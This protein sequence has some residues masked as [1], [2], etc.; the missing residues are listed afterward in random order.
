[1][2][3]PPPPKS[4]RCCCWSTSRRPRRRR[5]RATRAATRR[6]SWRRLRRRRRVVV[7]ETTRSATRMGRWRR[8]W[9]TTW[10]ARGRW[11]PRPRLPWP[12][13]RR[14]PE[15]CGLRRSGAC[16]ARSAPPCASRPTTADTW[17]GEPCAHYVAWCA[18][19]RWC[20]V[21]RC[22]GRCTSPCAACR[23]SSEPR[24]A[25]AR[26]AS[27]NTRSS[28]SRR[29]HLQPAVP[30][31]CWERGVHYASS[32]HCR[33]TTTSVTTARWPICCSSREAG[34]EAGLEEATITA[35]RGALP[36]P[37]T[38]VAAPWRTPGRRARAG[39][40]PPH[41]GSGR[42]PTPTPTS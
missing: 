40:T 10:S 32:W 5:R 38:A 4:Q 8:S 41:A 28:S 9:P 14:L 20:A 35:A 3:P 12:R 27:P 13:P 6:R 18:C 16:R 29:R 1:P 11:R 22:G 19:R 33:A 23:P 42:S 2:P 21:T 30:P 37:G 7:V 25:S 26:A 36:G 17:P 39:T 31:C 15:W 34:A 24:P